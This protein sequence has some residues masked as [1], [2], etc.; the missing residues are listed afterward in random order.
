MLGMLPIQR[1]VEP[2]TLRVSGMLQNPDANGVG[3]AAK[4]GMVTVL[5]IGDAVKP[6]ALTVSVI[7]D[8]VKPGT[9]KV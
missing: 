1:V 9:L 7:I 6:W 5:G 2:W 8:T 3:V 4:H